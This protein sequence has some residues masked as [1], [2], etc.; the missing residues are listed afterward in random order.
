MMLLINILAL[1]TV[2]LQLSIWLIN[3]DLQQF[4]TFYFG[5]RIVIST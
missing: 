1:E 5:W 4:D 2:I 3:K